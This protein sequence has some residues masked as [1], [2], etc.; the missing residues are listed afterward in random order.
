MMFT[1]EELLKFPHNGIRIFQPSNSCDLRAKTQP[2]DATL[3]IRLVAALSLNINQSFGIN[4]IE[5][6]R[7]QVGL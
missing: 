2:C 4:A 3:C 5:V 6:A 1:D 7:W